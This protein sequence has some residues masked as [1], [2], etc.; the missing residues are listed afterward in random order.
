ML[1]TNFHHPPILFSFCSTL[2]A[3]Y[4]R[5]RF[6][7]IAILYNAR[8]IRKCHTERERKGGE[9]DDGE[10]TAQWHGPVDA[11][12]A[13]ETTKTTNPS[14]P[15]GERLKGLRGSALCVIVAP[16]L[17]GL[18]STPVPSPMGY[19]SLSRS[20][21][22]LLSSSSLSSSW[23]RSSSRRRSCFNHVYYQVL[24]TFKI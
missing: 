8:I 13:G 14:S 7:P 2:I 10:V 11:Q 17:S 4:A 18:V 20:H 3:I 22:L 5:V 1:S 15:V 19:H 23:P 12:C 21:C 6:P 16:A 24:Q 9:R